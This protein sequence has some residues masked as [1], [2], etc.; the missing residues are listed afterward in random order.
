[1]IGATRW[2]IQAAL[3]ASVPQQSIKIV[4]SPNAFWSRSPRARFSC[5]W[6]SARDLQP[7]L[8]TWTW[9]RYVSAFGDHDRELLGEDWWI[10]GDVLVVT[11]Q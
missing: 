10:M 11:Q 8:S 3:T 2:T 6:P 4:Q 5:A 1:M 9:M 7:M